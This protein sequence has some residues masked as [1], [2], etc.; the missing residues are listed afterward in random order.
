MCSPAAGAAVRSV[1]GSPASVAALAMRRSSPI[2]GCSTGWTISRCWTCASAKTSPTSLTGPARHARGLQVGDP[3]RGRAR[4]Q[5]RGDERVDLVAVVHAQV[6]G[7]EARILEQLREVEHARQLEPDAPVDRRDVHVPVRRR[8]RPHR[9]ERGVVVAD[10]GRARRP[11]P[12][13]G[14]PGSPAGRSPPRAA[15]CAPRLPSPVRSRS[16]SATRMPTAACRP[17]ARSVTAY[18]DAHGLA[19]RAAPVTL[20]SPPMPCAIWSTPPRWRAGP[21]LPEAPRSTRRRSGGSPRG[22]PRSRRRG[23][24]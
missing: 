1:R 19:V 14:R 15:T 20:M 18:P 10:P 21:V 3:L 8:E 17:A 24:A 12:C 5:P 16:C 13:S 11:R 2:S 4:A 22:P 23:G 6:D 9:D 7:R